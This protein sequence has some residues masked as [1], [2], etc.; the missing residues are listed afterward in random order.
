SATESAVRTA[1]L[2]AVRENE[3]GLIDT[4]RVAQARSLLESASAKATADKSPPP[5]L[6]LMLDV[7]EALSQKP[8]GRS[9]S[10]V[11]DAETRAITRIARNQVQWALALRQLMPGDLAADYLWVG[12]ACGPSGFDIPD[13]AERDAVL[14]QSL[15]ASLIEFKNASSCSSQRTALQELLDREPR[16]VETNY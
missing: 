14:G 2:I 15:E 10:P 8:G 5:D 7:A 16:F 13:R 1:L 3:L 6:A 11:S 9:R 12:L 4:G